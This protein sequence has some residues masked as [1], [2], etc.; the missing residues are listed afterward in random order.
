[1]LVHIYFYLN[2][3]ITSI[4]YYFTKKDIDSSDEYSISEDDCVIEYE[5]L[6][7]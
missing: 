4:K 5:P 2:T 3:I 1:M 6:G 7:K